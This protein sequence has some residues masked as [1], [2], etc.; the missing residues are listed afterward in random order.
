M[1]EVLLSGCNLI[2]KMKPRGRMNDYNT[3]RDL[4]A[5]TETEG[6][7]TVPSDIFKVQAVIQGGF[8]P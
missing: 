3:F 1:L 7:Q 5:G 2:V 6:F 4:G 8:L